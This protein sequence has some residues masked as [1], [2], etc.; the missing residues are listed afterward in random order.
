MMAP[1]VVTLQRQLQ[2]AGAAVA[3]TPREAA[4]QV[5]E[6]HFM[7]TAGTGLPTLSWTLTGRMSR[8]LV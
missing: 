1:V 2:S 5:G 6:A 4:F 8:M 3:E 7:G